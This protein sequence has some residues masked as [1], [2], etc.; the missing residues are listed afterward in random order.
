MFPL[1]YQL[2]KL[3]IVTG[4]GNNSQNGGE[5]VCENTRTGK[6]VRRTEITRVDFSN[7]QE[8]KFRF[9]FLRGAEFQSQGACVADPTALAQVR[10]VRHETRCIASIIRQR[11]SGATTTA[12]KR[13]PTTVRT[14]G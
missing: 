14:E 7:T 13:D 4:I 6:E 3:M 11:N 5:N 12:A 10:V 2:V 1:P 8:N 9:A